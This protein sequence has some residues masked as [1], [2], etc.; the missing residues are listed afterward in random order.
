MEKAYNHRMQD[1]QK[2][3]VLKKGHMPISKKLEDKYSN[4]AFYAF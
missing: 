1:K 4:V 3:T 2:K